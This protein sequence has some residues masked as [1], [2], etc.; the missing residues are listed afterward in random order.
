MSVAAILVIIYGT[1][2]TAQ[3]ATYGAS[4]KSNSSARISD[5]VIKD[6]QACPDSR[7][8][9]FGQLRCY[10]H[11]HAENR[12]DLQM[13]RKVDASDVVQITL[14]EANKDFDGFVGDQRLLRAWVLKI[15]VRNL[16]DAKRSFTKTQRRDVKR[17]QSMPVPLHGN[18]ATASAILIE[19]ESEDQLRVAV[20]NLPFR[21]RQLVELRHRDGLS[22]NEIGDQ[23]NMSSA[24]ARQL[25][26]R[27]LRELKIQLADH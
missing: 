13:R 19:R 16:I 9:L 20:A 4:V 11:R 24:A 15:L 3:A 27:T 8:H 5:K 12:T 2:S 6:A 26:S 23:L 1:T 21:T 22:F 18:A 14:A 7:N 17:E 10:L 25:W